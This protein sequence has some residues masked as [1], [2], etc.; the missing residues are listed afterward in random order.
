MKYLLLCLLFLFTSCSNY[1]SNFDCPVYSGAGCKS[2]S[3]IEA[4]IEENERG[5][6][7]FTGTCSSSC[8]KKSCY[9]SVPSAYE[10]VVGGKAKAWVCPHFN[11]TGHYVDGHYIYFTIESGFTREENNVCN[12]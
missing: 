2:V 9:K 7:C 12:D 3:Q 6:D 4:M 8:N 5:S 11:S 10:E 1:R